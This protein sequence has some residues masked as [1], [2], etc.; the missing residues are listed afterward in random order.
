V[1]KL[2]GK[3]RLGKSKHKWENNIEIDKKKNWEERASTAC[4]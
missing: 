1:G 4:M 2:Y 3:I